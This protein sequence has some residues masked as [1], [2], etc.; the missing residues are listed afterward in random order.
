MDETSIS[1]NKHFISVI[2]LSTSE[3]NTVHTR[4]NKNAP[5]SMSEVNRDLYSVFRC[6]WGS[7][8]RCIRVVWLW[9][10][11]CQDCPPEQRTQRQDLRWLL[12]VSGDTII[13]KS[14]WNSTFNTLIQ[15]LL[16][17]FILV[18]HFRARFRECIKLIAASEITMTS[19]C[20]LTL[21][22]VEGLRDPGSVRGRPGQQVQVW[23]GP[24]P[25]GGCGHQRSVEISRKIF[26]QCPKMILS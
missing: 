10:S 8:C 11:P 7:R 21:R 24:L 25:L 18:V 15:C 4:K 2:E 5:C 14:I 13:L 1:K 3:I 17:L 22:T 16:I 19:N 23:T 20:C 12:L 9:P 6:D 26:K